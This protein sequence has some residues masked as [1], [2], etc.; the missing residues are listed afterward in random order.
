MCSP[1][2]NS[3][4]LRYNIV[5]FTIERKR[6]NMTHRIVRFGSLMLVIL[7]VFA[8]SASAMDAPPP[9]PPG[10]GSFWFYTGDA[11]TNLDSGDYTEETF[12]D[13]MNATEVALR[14][15]P[16]VTAS[17][18]DCAVTKTAGD[19][20][21]D[22]SSFYGVN[23]GVLAYSEDAATP[24]ELTIKGGTV[25][26][27]AGG[28]NGIFAYGNS[29]I[30]LE[31]VTVTTTGAGG[32]GGIM[33]AGGGTLY[34][35]NCTV[36]TEGGSS[37]AI[38]SDRGSGVM[39]IDGGTYISNG[40]LGTGSPA[41]YCVADIT[42]ANATL[43]AGNAQAICFEGRN[44]FHMY[45][46]FLEGN[47]TASDDDE[48]CNVMVYQSMSGDSEEGTTYCTMVGGVLKANN[49][50]ENG[51][52]KMFYTTNTYCYI[53]L[54][55][56]Q[57][58]YAPGM[59][60]FLLCAC[61]TN[62]RGW[63][64]AGANGSECVLYTKDQKMEHNIIFDTWSYLGCFMTE[65]SEWTGALLCRENN[66][67]R[68]CDLYLDESSVWNVTGD[69]V[70]R[71]LYTGGG[72][73]NGAKIVD[74]E[75]NVLAG[76]GE[77][78]V[79][80]YGTYSEEDHSGYEYVPGIGTV[81]D[82]EYT[83]DTEAAEEYVNL[84]YVPTAPDGTVYETAAWNYEETLEA[85]EAPAEEA[86]A[87]DSA[88]EEAPASAAEEAPAA[89]Q[90]ASDSAPDASAQESQVEET[91]GEE[92]APSRVPVVPIAVGAVAVIAAGAGIGLARKKKS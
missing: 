72:A 34:A 86:P 43:S 78:T 41:I 3:V 30:D 23:A 29:T 14:V 28:A 8:L 36:T 54:S 84:D 88:V 16:G 51:N 9:P 65:G 6:E 49:V 44:P 19:L 10:G 42:A 60:T 64:R 74:P 40:S 47:Y 87:E 89:V 2:D 55:D 45:N 75:G 62:H 77:Y 58:E 79:T 90:T 70:V 22:D 71:D 38:R 82:G 15:G 1:D 13:S 48:N 39:V 20:Y 59:E 57:M 52:A 83:F 24:A 27:G 7:L 26:T 73:I 11:V 25:E 31:D 21:G 17:L 91:S 81:K 53:S 33:V 61:N 35:K 12:P 69:S 56:V 68:G 92:N 76:D 67:D 18:T 80:V 32:A 4:R 46:C 37:A 85:E 5:E 50:S 66:G 63:G